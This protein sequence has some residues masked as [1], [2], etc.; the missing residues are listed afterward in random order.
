MLALAQILMA[1]VFLLSSP[2]L[3]AEASEKKTGE[4]KSSVPPSLLAQKVL[5]PVARSLPEGAS[6]LLLTSIPFPIPYPLYFYP[7]PCRV[8][9]KPLPGTE[10]ALRGGLEPLVARR[11]QHYFADLR[12]RGWLLAEG[13]GGEEALRSAMEGVDYVLLFG[14]VGQLPEPLRMEKLGS[15]AWGGLY[16]VRG[17]KAKGE[18]R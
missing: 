2:L 11:V 13:G 12:A 5:P 4:K 6:T 18:G 14:F 9:W 17:S 10:E 15:Y 3:T 16:R 7:K 8:L 1:L